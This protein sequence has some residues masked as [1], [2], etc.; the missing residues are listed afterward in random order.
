MSAVAARIGLS[1]RS[2]PTVRDFA[3]L[4]TT[5][6]RH[7][8]LAEIVQAVVEDGRIW[9]GWDRVIVL[10]RRG[11]RWQ[12][13]GVTG[14]TIIATRASATVRLQALV[15]ELAHSRQSWE[16]DRREPPPLSARLR[17]LTTD[18]LAVSSPS[19][20][21]VE[22]VWLAAG[23]VANSPV[24]PRSLPSFMLV[25]ESFG[26]SLNDPERDERTAQLIEQA[27]LALTHSRTFSRIWLRPVR[28]AC[29]EAWNTV[30]VT[31]WGM[32]TLM[33]LLLAVLGGWLGFQKSHLEVRAS[34]QLLPAQRLNVFAPIEGEVE[35]IFVRSGER[36][37]AGQPLLQLSQ[38][39]L[40]EDQILTQ[41]RLAE[42]EQKLQGTK[43]ELHEVS[44]N[45]GE[46]SEIVRLQTRITQTQIEMQGLRK[47]LAHLGELRERLMVRAPA[48]GLITTS[49]LERRLGTRPLQRGELLMEIADDAGPWQLELKVPE[50]ELGKFFATEQTTVPVATTLKFRSLSE[51]GQHHQAT[52]T[53]TS[54]RMEV[55]PVSG[56]CLSI[57]ALPEQK[58]PAL[59]QIG[60]DV[61]ARLQGPE[62]TLA[63]VLF[64]DLVAAFHRWSW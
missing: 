59:Q 6:H 27:T 40:Q 31:R 48:A 42:A 50:R 62:T 63:H 9:T 33:L 5:L 44:Q 24:P 41:S 3:A 15:A 56:P 26:D 53:A 21:R 12:T 57:I 23:Q 18:Y 11:P 35:S 14:Q 54:A 52:V 36:V 58:H 43:A 1:T 10:Q 29:G 39:R 38:S 22:P 46:R 51:P 60:M 19:R 64:F 37:A 13:L 2:E 25:F 45:S 49:D 32:A 55:D 8:D 30:T 61:E 47:Q 16:L 28:R 4:V 17:T 34:G 7:L 20:L